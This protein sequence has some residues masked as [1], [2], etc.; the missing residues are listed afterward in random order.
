MISYIKGHDFHYETENLC[1]VFFPHEKIKTVYEYED[2]SKIVETVVS[3]RENGIFIFAKANIDGKVSERSETLAPNTE[4]DEIERCLAVL[5]FDVFKE[6]TGYRPAWGILTGVRPSKLMNRL[7]EEYGEKGAKDYFENRLLVSPEKTALAMEVAHNEQPLMN[8]SEPESYS[9]YLSIPFCPTRCSYCSFVSHSIKQAKKLVPDY[10]RLL[11]EELELTA[12]IAAELGLKL[13][14]V[15]YGGGTPTSLDAEDLDKITATVA[16]C[17]PLEN[18]REYTVEAGR[19]DTITP[20]KLA[21]LKKNG[22]SRISINP[23]TFEDKVLETI[24]RRHTAAQTVQAFKMAREAGFDNINMDLIA[25]LPLDNAEGFARTLSKVRELDPESVTIHTL[26]LKRSSTLVTQG[27]ESGE[28]LEVPK[29]LSAAQTV[30]TDGDYLPYYMYR[31]S[32]SLGNME[33]VGWCKKGFEGLY[34]IYMMEECHTILSAGAGAVTKLKA[35]LDN[36]IERIFNFKYPYEYNS[37]FE[38]L[39]KRKE[40]IKPFY[41]T[42]NAK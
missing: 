28:A 6:I 34:N 12:K 11:C 31:Q 39:M 36:Y 5:L 19:P 7:E 23:Q 29:M 33:N 15:Y 38:E 18:I 35:P 26:A 10:V 32:R 37:R 4:N 14:T 21:V 22:V 8:L 17:F 30:L 20:E 13:E 27:Q 41:E 24:G 1:R 3:E 16:R 9:L 42:Y 25:G 2:D 40:R